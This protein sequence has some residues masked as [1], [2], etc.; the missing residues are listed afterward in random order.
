MGGGGS[1]VMK[2]ACVLMICMV[3]AAP[4]AVEAAI[5]CGQVTSKLVPCLG[6]LQKGGS[7]SPGCC[8][9]IKGLN[10]GAQTKEDRQAVCK[11]LKTLYQ[12]RK[13]PDLGRA[14]GLPGQCGVS[15][16]FKI[17]PSTDCSKY[18]YP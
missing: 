15:I 3:V 12:S 4:A 8:S 13:V 18:V 17:S 14:S 2:V 6:Y 16:P 10:S 7:V 11:C 9:G 5:S 1:G